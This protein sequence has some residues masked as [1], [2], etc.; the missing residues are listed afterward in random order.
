VA[1][2]KGR[3]WMRQSSPAPFLFFEKGMD[4]VDFMDFM[5]C[6]AW[7]AGVDRDDRMGGV[8]AA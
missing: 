3:G 7:V 6:W 5:D 1:L 8:I 2:E 4:L